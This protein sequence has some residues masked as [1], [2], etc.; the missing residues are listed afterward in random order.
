MDYLGIFFVEY[1]ERA[2]RNWP[3]HEFSWKNQLAIPTVSYSLKDQPLIKFGS[4]VFGGYPGTHR[5]WYIVLTEI[6]YNIYACVAIYPWQFAL[7]KLLF[8]RSR[9]GKFYLLNLKINPWLGCVR[10]TVYIYRVWNCDIFFTAIKIRI[11]KI[12]RK[13]VEIRS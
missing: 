10:P 5:L 3:N 1:L 6:V 9:N 12:C 11:L 7:V 8:L 2:C 4:Q 13:M